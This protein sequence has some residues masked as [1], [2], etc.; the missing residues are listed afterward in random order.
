MICIQFLN[1]VPY[2]IARVNGLIKKGYQCKCLLDYESDLFKPLSSVKHNLN[3]D[4]IN[5][6]KIFIKTI[7]IINYFFKNDFDCVFISGYQEV[8]SLASIIGAYLTNTK[9]ILFSESQETDKKNRNFFIEI[10]KKIII[11][12]FNGAIV[13]GNCH[14]DYLIKLGM[15]KDSI[16][17]GYDCVDNDYFIAKSQ[18]K[19]SKLKDDIYLCCICRFVEKKNLFVLIKSFN[20][21]KKQFLKYKKTKLKI[22]G[23]GP[24]L[25]SLRFYIKQNNISDVELVGP[26]NYENLPR[27]YSKSNGLIL[28]STTEQWGLVTNEALNCGIPVLISQECGS[29]EVI[30]ENINGYIVN[31]KSIEKIALK[32]NQLIELSL[33]KETEFNCRESIKEI[34]PLNFGNSCAKAI[35]KRSKK[36][37]LAIAGFLSI[38]ILLAIKNL[39]FTGTQKFEA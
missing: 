19:N 3:V 20:L 14:K 37:H 38:V 26:I 15:K 17:K 9:I 35:N 11:N 16:F 18:S 25:E 29:K 24:L 7:K 34:S 32:I 13:G 23:T 12:I 8:S 36:N 22:G 21:F 2:N 5:N 6:K 27:F 28:L 39:K 10:Y 4:I 31:P 33:N 30:K 1:L